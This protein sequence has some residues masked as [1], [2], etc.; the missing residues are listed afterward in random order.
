VGL[1]EGGTLLVAM[2]DSTEYAS[3]ND[4]LSL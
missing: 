1:D 2:T 3:V 4:C